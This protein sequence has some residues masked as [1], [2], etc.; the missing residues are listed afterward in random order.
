ME[1][2]FV[3]SLSPVRRP[4]GFSRRRDWKAY[5]FPLCL[6]QSPPGLI[7]LSAVLMDCTVNRMLYRR[8][9]FSAFHAISLMVAAGVAAGQPTSEEFTPPKG[10]FNAFAGGSRF[11]SY[12]GSPN[13]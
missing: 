13:R 2:R 9:P 6:V 3:R 4:T 12:Q 1:K 5:L 7:P 8:L 10:E 11:F